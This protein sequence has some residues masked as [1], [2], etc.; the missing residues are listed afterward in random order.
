MV[1]ADDGKHHAS[2]QMSSI[3]KFKFHSFHVKDKMVRNSLKGQPIRQVDILVW[4]TQHRLVWSTQHRLVWS[5]QHQ[6]VWSTQHQLTQHQLVWST[7]HQLVWSTQ[8]QLV[9]STQ[10]QLVWSSQ[11]QLVW[12]AASTRLIYAASTWYTQHQLDLRGWALLCSVTS[13]RPS[14]PG[15]V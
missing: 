10:H 11:H 13:F 15:R 14:V 3:H 7:Q 5:T 9:W 8:H 4:S 6:L 2:L 1:G 12:Y